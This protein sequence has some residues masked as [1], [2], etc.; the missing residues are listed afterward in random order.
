MPKKVEISHKTI[1]FTAIFLLTLWILYI[2]RDLIIAIFVALLIMA[3][4]DP[5]V[6][7]LSRYKIPRSLSVVLTYV[8]VLFLFSVIAASVVPPLVSQTSGFVSDIPKSLEN[9]GVSTYISDQVTQQFIGQLGSVPARLAKVTISLFSNVLGIVTIFVF[10]F[11]LLSDRQMLDNQLS[12]LFGENKAKET[13]KIV[14]LLEKRLG[15]WARAQLTLMFVVGTSTFI[16][17]TILGIPFALPLALLAGLLEIVPYAGPIIAAIPAVII[18]FGISPVMGLA[19]AALSFLIQQLENYV[20]VPKIMQRSV[21][22]SPIVTL[23]ALS[24]GFRLAGVLG[25]L[26][27][28]PVFL[29]LQVIVREYFTTKDISL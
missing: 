11:Y 28:V 25:L 23:L 18:G 17:L 14:T 4:L 12:G 24:I 27:S 6:T 13:A 8:L 9:I 5:M 19:T 7:R 2:I 3:V 21:G 1:I 22:V 15:G 16:G 10:A 29:T 20:F 26:I